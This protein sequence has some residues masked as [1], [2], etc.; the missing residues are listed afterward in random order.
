M[1]KLEEYL[2]NIIYRQEQLAKTMLIL[3]VSMVVVAAL[4]L[5]IILTSYDDHS[6]VGSLAVSISGFI[7]SVLLVGVFVIIRIHSCM[8]GCDLIKVR[9][10]QGGLIAAEKALS[11]T[12]CIKD[13]PIEKIKT[14]IPSGK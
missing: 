7:V 14:L 8:N 2:N 10:S 11:S 13:F 6:F 12:C 4:F 3:V 9:L 5:V 1:E